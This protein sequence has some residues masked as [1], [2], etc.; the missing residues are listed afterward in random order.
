MAFWIMVCLSAKV[1]AY[2]MQSSGSIPST[3]PTNFFP[4]VIQMSLIMNKVKTCFFV[5]FCL[6]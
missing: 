3:A 4:F 6:F 2:H 1:Y 5:G